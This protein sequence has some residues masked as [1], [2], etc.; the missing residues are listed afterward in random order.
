M[1]VSLA[2]GQWWSALESLGLIALFV[3]GAGAGSLMV[4]GRGANRQPWVLLAEALL[5]AAGAALGV[6]RH[7]GIVRRDRPQPSDVRSPR[8][9]RHHRARYPPQFG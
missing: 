8:T 5:L 2:E 4:L 7:S 6:G 1:G 9:D 3:V